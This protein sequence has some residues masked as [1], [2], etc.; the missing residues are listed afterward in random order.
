MY[1]RRLAGLPPEYGKLGTERAN[2]TIKSIQQSLSEEESGE[3]S[4]EEQVP[5]Y[6]L[7]RGT[8][9][10][11]RTPEML[12]ILKNQAPTD[13]AGV[14]AKYMTKNFRNQQIPSLYSSYFFRKD[15]IKEFQRQ[16]INS[17]PSDRFTGF[18]LSIYNLYNKDDILNNTTY[19]PDVLGS[20]DIEKTRGYTADSIENMQKT[21]NFL[22]SQICSSIGSAYTQLALKRAID[23]TSNENKFDI[24]IASTKVIEN[25]SLSIEERLQGVVAFVIVELGECKKYPSAYSINLICTGKNAISGTGSVLMG[26]YLYTLL[27][28]PDNRTPSSRIVFPPGNSFLKV[29]SKELP[30]GRIV[31][32][33]TFGS[34]ER[35]VPT[36]QIGVLELAGAY[37]NTGGL[38][39]YEKFGF[40]Y[41]QTMFSNEARRIQC[42]DDRDNLPMI[43]DFNTKPGYSELDVD[44][45]KEKVVNITAGIDR[46]FE[47]SKICSIRNDKQRLLGILKSVK[48]HIDNTP[49]ETLDDFFTGT[50]TDEIIQQVIEMHADPT[51]RKAK[52]VRKGTLEEVIDYL[53]SHPPQPEHPVM[54]AKIDKIITFL[55][56]VIKN[57][58][59]STLKFYDTKSRRFTRKN[60]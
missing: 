29:S 26:A 53:E 22:S 35:L 18:P 37:V 58:G 24:L 47:K 57:G 38:C 46:G 20:R 7:S 27:T 11:L 10:P 25:V 17:V 19:R 12:E 42:F 44:G 43:I 51:A 13:V 15:I 30:D 54:A 8:S 40:T 55:P 28:H 45:Q 2:P 56:P 52:P 41:D 31:E 34:D 59:G 60:R 36:Q 9:I 16:V 1:S 4:E 49:G 48:L 21:I 23:L 50:F 5:D 39:M 6:S 33:C 3:E 14:I 32:S